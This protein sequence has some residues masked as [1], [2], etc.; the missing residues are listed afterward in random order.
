M[1]TADI[2]PTPKGEREFLEDVVK[3]WPR[4][5]DNELAE[6]SVE[7][8]AFV[9]GMEVQVIQFS[10]AQVS[11]LVL[12][13]HNK[14]QFA[15]SYKAIRADTQRNFSRGSQGNPQ[16]PAHV[17]KAVRC[18]F[19]KAAERTLHSMAEWFYIRFADASDAAK[20]NAA[21]NCG[22][23]NWI[24]VAIEQYAGKAGVEQGCLS[25]AAVLLM[26]VAGV[27]TAAWWLL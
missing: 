9:R 22:D 13:C 5:Q 17:N 2:K 10:F 19:V 7:E 27:P 8:R 25:A 15:K 18:A 14:F 23:G 6:C 24:K 4:L 1:A 16:M 26:V 12:N 20:A 21:L 3:G 11:D